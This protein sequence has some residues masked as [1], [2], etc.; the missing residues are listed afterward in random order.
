MGIL[1]WL[2]PS[3]ADRL[4][5]AR[6]LM[7]AGRYE[8]AR[9]GLVHCKSPEADALYDECSA[10]VDKAT[11]A[12]LKKQA[13]AAGFRGWKVEVSMKDA[14][15]RARI[16]ALVTRELEKAGIDLAA[17]DIDQAAAEAALARAGQKARNKGMAGAGTMKLVPIMA[18]SR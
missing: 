5:T 14:R 10:H 1:S 9:K 15:S 17:P 4:R 7:A 11:S 13:H 18:G 16:E 8:E 2:F 12:S 3:D 6:T